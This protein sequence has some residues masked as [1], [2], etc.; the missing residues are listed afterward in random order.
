MSER[1]RRGASRGFTLLEVM[2]S[3]FILGLIL[4]LIGYEF[5]H[6]V[7][8]MLHTQSNVDAESNARVIMA[9]I[10]T[11]LRA[12]TPNLQAPNNTQIML[13]PLTVGSSTSLSY[14]RVHQGALSDPNKVNLVNGAP[15]PAF[16]DVTIQCKTACS[17]T[18]PDQLVETSVDDLLHTPV[19]SRTIGHDVTNFSV[20][21]NGGDSATGQVTIHLSVAHP[22]D[23]KR[24]N[25]TTSR[26]NPT[27][28]FTVESSVEVGS[29]IQ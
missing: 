16:D 3:V 19:S 27:C 21:Y 9:K 24:N 14:K 4:L 25:Y 12:A 29:S 22:F 20:D 23:A 1:R 13:N 7:S 15:A 28:I 10:E 2:T 6:T 5:D 18:T 26:C 17:P 8:H 11:G